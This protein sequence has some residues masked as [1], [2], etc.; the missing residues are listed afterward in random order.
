MFRLCRKYKEGGLSPGA[1]YDE[2][3]GEFSDILQ[4]IANKLDE[5]SVNRDQFR[6]SD[7]YDA[8]DYARRLW[9][10]F[11]M[12]LQRGDVSIDNNLCEQQMRPIAIYRNNSLFCGSHKGAERL[13]NVMSLIQ[14]CRLHNV[15]VY[16]YLCDVLNRLIDYKGN[17][18]DL[19]PHRWKPATS[20]A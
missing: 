19:L 9:P 1:I 14:S 3:L 5:L 15:N 10:Y 20:L 4:K 16:D 8:V 11:I 12:V 18:M 6:H 17:L 2:R 13:A 7:L